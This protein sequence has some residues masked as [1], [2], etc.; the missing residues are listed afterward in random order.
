M[1]KIV[2]KL[3]EK[4][5]LDNPERY[6]NGYYQLSKMQKK[7][8]VWGL[9]IA[10]ILFWCIRALVSFNQKNYSLDLVIEVILFSSVA[11]LLLSYYAVFLIVI[12]IRLSKKLFNSGLNVED[13]TKYILWTIFLF[14]I[15]FEIIFKVKLP[16][17]GFLF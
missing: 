9:F 6:A 8:W 1:K 17:V 7:V 2:I 15:M 3:R 4:L 5:E 13:V 11:I 14:A 16:F 10:S 12:S